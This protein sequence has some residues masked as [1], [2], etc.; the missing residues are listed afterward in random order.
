VNADAFVSEALGWLPES[1]SHSPF[2]SP[3]ASE[4]ATLRGRDRRYS[5]VVADDNA[6]MRVYIASLLRDRFDVRTVPDGRA[7][8]AQARADRPDAI[9]SDVMTPG[10]DGFA[11]LRELRADRELRGIPVILLS[12]RAGEE[13]RIEGLAS[14][15]DDYLIKPFGGRELVARVEST[16]KLAALRREKEQ[17]LIDNQ[18]RLSAEADAMAR[19]NELSTRLWRCRDLQRRAE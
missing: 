19:L 15:A 17:A 18:R 14:G 3:D 4:F 11:M 13:S 9:L 12:A 16:V 7:A 1:D 8:I 10:L 2:D 5:I 6:D